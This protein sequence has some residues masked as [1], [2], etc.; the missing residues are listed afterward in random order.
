MVEEQ[1][2]YKS[3][4]NNLKAATFSFHPLKPITTGEG[5][6]VTTNNKNFYSTAKIFRSH[7]MI[8]N[9]S[10]PWDNIQ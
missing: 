10:K 8:R 6:M 2:L 7:G 1:Y 5:G 4:I 3:A 9:I